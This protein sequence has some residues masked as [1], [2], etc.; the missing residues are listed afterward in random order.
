MSAHC[1]P[2][3]PGTIQSHHTSACAKIKIEL[4]MVVDQP[5]H[6]FVTRVKTVV[7][8]RKKLGLPTCQEYMQI[9]AVANRIR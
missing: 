3:M 4:H 6:E 5:N 1:G 8:V 9:L 7:T 2:M